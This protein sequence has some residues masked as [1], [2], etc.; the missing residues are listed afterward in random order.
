MSLLA[1]LGIASAAIAQSPSAPPSSTERPTPAPA[2]PAPGGDQSSSNQPAATPPSD[3]AKPDVKIENKFEQRSQGTD[4]P[5]DPSALPR[6]ATERTT[7]FGL[8]PMAAVIIAAALFVVV[9]LAI[10]AMTRD[11][12]PSVDNQAL[13][14]RSDHPCTLDA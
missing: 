9:I 4:R 12:T 11:S 7:I 10:V 14:P 3:A 5:S 6:A 1:M 8:S 2:S 13:S